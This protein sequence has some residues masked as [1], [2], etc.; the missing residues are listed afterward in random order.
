MPRPKTDIAAVRK[1][2]LEAAERHIKA[3]GPKKLTVSDIAAECGMSQSNAYRFF[4]SKRDLLEAVGER[5]FA[6]IERELADIAASRQPPAE[7]LVRFVARQYELKRARYTE[8]PELFR[9]YFALGAANASIVERHLNR[10]HAQLEAIMQRCGE[11]GLLGG[12]E[13]GEAANLVE[14]MTVRFRDPGQIMRF[15]EADTPG[16]VAEIAG[17]ILA[18]LAHLRRNAG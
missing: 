8:D 11:K 10:I 15:Y 17:L 5:W 4:H 3:H 18:G 13:P 14:A 16:R 1:K 12:R 6:E 7:Q 9:A 2:L